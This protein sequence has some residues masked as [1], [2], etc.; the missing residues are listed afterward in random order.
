MARGEVF[1]RMTR[2]EFEHL[3]DLPGKAIVGDI[4]LQEQRAVRP[5]LRAE[6]VRIENSAGVDLRLT[7]TYNPQTGSKSVNVHVPGLGPIC[8]L[9][10]DGQRHPPAGRSHKHS[11]RSADCPRANLPHDVAPRP[12][13]SGKLLHEVFEEFCRAANIEHGGMFHSP[14]R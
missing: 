5:L 8:R 1:R 7:L 13:L 10:V 14:E 3:R 2:A 9:E 6:D 11:L 4:R 12:E